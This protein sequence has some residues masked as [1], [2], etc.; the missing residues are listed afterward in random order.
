MEAEIKKRL[1]ELAPDRVRFDA[2]LAGLTTL[3]IGGPAEVL[4]EPESLEQLRGVMNLVRRES[5]PWFILG[6]GSNVL[7]DDQGFSGVVLRLGQG[8]A[9]LRVLESGGDEVLVEAGAAAL[10]A[11]LLSLSRRQGLSGL[12]F[13]AGIPGRLGGALAMNAGAQGGQVM[14]AVHSLE[15]LEA[16]NNLGRLD[17]DELRASYR[18]LDLPPGTVILK[19]IF[20]LHRATTEEVGARIEQVLTRRRQTQ[21]HGV[22]SAGC[23]FKNPPGD[24]AGRLIDRA[25]LKGRQIGQVWVSEEHANFIVHR[26]RATSGQVLELMEII[27]RDV[28]GKFGVELE[29]EI[30][31]VG[32]APQEGRT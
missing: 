9:S 22:R 16:S 17:R 23:V 21:P 18:Q 26:G 24:S 8:F 4:I 31:I 3:Q 30:K 11:G 2:P 5:L 1:Q 13:L 27:R 14:D 25:G 10:T 6:G 7:F 29:P 19:G 32:R 15:V 20:R 28:K 12:E